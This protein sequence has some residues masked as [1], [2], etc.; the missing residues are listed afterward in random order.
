[1]IRTADGQALKILARGDCTSR[2]SIALNQD[3]FERPPLFL[4]NEKS[5]FVQFLDAIRGISVTE[6]FLREISDV[7]SMP[8]VLRS[9]Y[10][11]QAG[12]SILHE[13]DAD[14]LMLDSYADMNFQLWENNAAGFKLW[15]HPKFVHDLEG[16]KETHR[17]L[18]HRTLEQSVDDAVAFIEYI[19]TLNPQIPV[20]FLNQQVDHY[21]KLADRA[22]DFEKLG[23]LVATR[24]PDVFFGGVVSK[25]DL[26]LADIGS[27]GGPGNTLH[28]QGSTYRRMW[29]RAM[30]DGLEDAL[31]RRHDLIAGSS[32]NLESRDDSHEVT[33]NTR[34]AGDLG[35]TPSPRRHIVI[36]ETI[37]LD[38][39]VGSETCN[40]L[41]ARAYQDVQR[42][43]ANY[44]YLDGRTD[45][46]QP[47]RFTPML[48][49]LEE[50]PTFDLWEAHIKK[51]SGGARLRHKRKAMDAGYYTKP[52]PY[53][54]HI[55]DIYEINTS[56][57]NRSGGPIR[58]NLTRSIEEL[59]GAPDRMF[60]VPAVKCPRHWQQTYG[61]FLHDAGHQ[62]GSVEVG[63]RLVAYVSL[64]R[65]GEF[66]LYSQIIGHGE[67][68]AK[69]V[70]TLLHHDVVRHLY[71]N[72]LGR[73]TGLRYIMYGG[74]QNG[75]EGLYQFKHRAGFKPYIVNVPPA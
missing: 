35:F 1:M 72:D 33:G 55:P 75:G 59:G 65:R 20:L 13:H 66:V 50:F 45:T 3:L 8:R 63:E 74:V 30:R 4:Q 25:E 48:I 6:D 57:D 27:A 29:D 64:R 9:F 16:F 44:F 43:L 42:V 37:D 21:P 11:G 39:Q 26:D 68:L 73:P 67:H 52:F 40:E 7:D 36:T 17:S 2:R 61:V 18:G 32:Q 10:L 41:C 24:L 54:L 58:S 38:L 28:F 12:R 5:T 14:L 34:G 47:P 60:Q 70:L 53:R 19:R 46:G 15:I 71:E 69:G 22:A 56:R 23:A 49:D 62:Q 51:F 31:L